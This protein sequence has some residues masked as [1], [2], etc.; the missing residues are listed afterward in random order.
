[1]PAAGLTPGLTIVTVTY[2]SAATIAGFL[3]ACPAGVPVVLVDNASTDETIEVAQRARPDLVVIANA[4]NRGFGAA[5]NQGLDAVRTEFAL[6]ANPDARLSAEAIAALLAAA[7][8]FPGHRLLAPLLLDE[9]GAPV[10]SWNAGQARRRRLPR[11]RAGEPWPEGPICVEFA[12]GACL[13][14]RPAEG[15]RFDPGF[16]LFYEDDDLCHRAGGALL[17][18]AARVAHAGGGSSAP[19]RAVSWRK[20]HCMAWSRLR[21]T[22]LH[23][24]GPAVARREAARRLAHH[25]GKAAGHALTLQAGKLRADLAGLAGTLAWLRGRGGGHPPAT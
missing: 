18:P 19:S 9:A 16:F 10:R 12:S 23:G 4:A 13:L 24:G 20:A 17:V 1:M 14:L 11:D 25:A 6:L 8:A 5:A 15:L 22:A 7:E 3:A 2:H 21:F